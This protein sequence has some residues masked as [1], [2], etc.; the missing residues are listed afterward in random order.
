[1]PLDYD[2][3]YINLCEDSNEEI[4]LTTD[5]RICCSA[6]SVFTLPLRVLD[7]TL[8]DKREMVVV[9]HNDGEP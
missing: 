8:W 9:S 5:L 3:F 6:R 1:M 4:V 2:D 7:L